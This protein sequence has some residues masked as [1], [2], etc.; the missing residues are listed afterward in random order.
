MVGENP[1]L[2]LNLAREESQLHRNGEKLLRQEIVQRGGLI[3]VERTLREYGS[4]SASRKKLGEPSS[5]GTARKMRS[6]YLRGRDL[7]SE[8]IT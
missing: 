1:A 3:K 4:E 2:L 6:L 8:R 5:I 7:K